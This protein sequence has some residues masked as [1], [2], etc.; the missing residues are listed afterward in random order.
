MHP[1]EKRCTCSMQAAGLLLGVERRGLDDAC[2]SYLGVE[3]PKNLQ[4]S[5]WGAPALS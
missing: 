1:L 3:V 5:D 4:T 2:F